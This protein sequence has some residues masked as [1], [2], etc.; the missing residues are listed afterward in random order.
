MKK[1]VINQK[2]KQKNTLITEYKNT[3]IK[4]SEHYDSTT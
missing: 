4:W 2:Q 3:Q 1:S